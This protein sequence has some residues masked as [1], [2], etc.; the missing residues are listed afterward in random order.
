MAATV[1][2]CT[3]ADDWTRIFQ[4]NSIAFKHDHPYF[5]Y[6][7]PE[8]W[9]PEG[10][11]AG[12]KRL[13][14]MLQT[15]PH[16]RFFKATV[17]EDGAPKIVGIAKWLLYDKLDEIPE[18]GGLDDQWYPSEEAKELAA[19]VASVYTTPRWEKINETRGRVVCEW[20]VSSCR[21]NVLTVS[22]ASP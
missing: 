21:R 5:D 18:R 3:E 2:C 6:L 11:V 20:T 14:E 1:S 7:F 8:H 12:G 16:A 17:E 19:Y 4:I 13:L 15:D 22:T 10:Q 9:T